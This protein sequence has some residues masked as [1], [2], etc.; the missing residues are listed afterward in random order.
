MKKVF[1]VLLLIVTL[2]IPQLGCNAQDPNNN[3][4]VSKTSFHLDTVCTVTIYTMEGLEELS[5]EEQQKEALL[6]ITD[7]FKLC[8][9][10]E[11]VLSKTIEGS[12][13]DKLNKAKGGWVTASADT[14]ELIKMGK[15][16]GDK[17]GGVFDITIGKATDLWNFHDEDDEGNK[18]G[19][20]P[21]QSD[22]KNAVAHVD[23]SKIEINGSK[24]RLA[25]SQMQLDLGG[26]AKGYIADKVTEFLEKK[27][28][29]SGVVNLGGNIVV[30]G[31]KGASLTEYGEAVD[32]SVGIGSPTS[33]SGELLC[34]IPGADMTVVTSGTYERYF[35]ADG[36]KYHHVL[37]PKTGYPFETDLLSV[38]II[39][40]KGNS[41]LCDVMSTSALALGREKAVKM[42]KGYPDVKAVLVDAD[43][44]VTSIGIEID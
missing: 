6:L 10:Y 20:V 22:L 39:G 1:T 7:A 43:G 42:I 16:W 34:T 31:Q 41:A 18:T 38:T 26:I 23:Y 28:V 11:K 13:I 24:V 15:E 2:I 27:G 3:P 32:F 30:I 33:N 4:G 35:E 29:T 44:E 12:D 40:T 14:L 8:D 9:N 5:D 37:N 21:A 25:D 36:K 19:T 17:S